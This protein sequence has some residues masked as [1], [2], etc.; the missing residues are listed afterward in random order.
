MEV[1]Q[2]LKFH[3]KKERLSFMENWLTLEKHLTEDE[4][5]KEDL[6]CRLLQGNPEDGLDH[7]MQFINSYED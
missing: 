2:M 1:L 3:L 5:D 6:L 4:Q 7:I